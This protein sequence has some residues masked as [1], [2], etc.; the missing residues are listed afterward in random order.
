MRSNI[1][2]CIV[3]SILGITLTV[4]T[5]VYDNLGIEVALSVF[6]ICYIILGLIILWNMR[7]YN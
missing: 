3:L 7:Q 2:W 5:I 6:I 1:S 4:V